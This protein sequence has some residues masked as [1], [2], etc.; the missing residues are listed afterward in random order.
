MIAFR[1]YQ[2]LEIVADAGRGLVVR[3]EYALDRSRGVCAQP[4][5]KPLRIVA[6]TPLLGERLDV[7]TVRTR[8]RSEP[9]PERPDAHAEQLVARREQIDDDRFERSRARTSE[10]HDAIARLEDLSQLLVEP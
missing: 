8:D 7:R 2:R 9:V 5:P 4:I 1:F 3:E 6:P 10:Q